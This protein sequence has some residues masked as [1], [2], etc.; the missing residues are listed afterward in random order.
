MRLR[1]ITIKCDCCGREEEI[2]EGQSPSPGYYEVR[3]NDIR[4]DVCDKEDAGGQSCKDKLLYL[5]SATEEE[6]SRL[7]TK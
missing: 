3:I 5:L 7:A 4:Y 6:R 2:L 1:K